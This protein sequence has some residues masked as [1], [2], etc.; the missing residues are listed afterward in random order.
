MVGADSGLIVL[1]GL[2]IFA[3]MLTCA[4][5]TLSSV[6]SQSFTCLYAP[7]AHPHPRLGLLSLMVHYLTISELTS[8]ASYTSHCLI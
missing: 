7:S 5:V 3:I 8:T 4:P 2:G 1:L 6:A